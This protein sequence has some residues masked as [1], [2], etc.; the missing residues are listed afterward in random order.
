MPR[1]AQ[2]GLCIAAALYFILTALSGYLYSPCY[3]IAD[4]VY[5]HGLI[6][7]L[8]F[9]YTVFLVFLLSDARYRYY[10]NLLRVTFT[11]LSLTLV[12][13]FLFN[14]IWFIN[15]A[16]LAYLI[17]T[18]ALWRYFD[19][20]DKPR[21]DLF[22]RLAIFISLLSWIYFIY[23]LNFEN[24]LGFESRFSY[25]LLAFSF[26]VSL[27]LFSRIVDILKLSNKQVTITAIVLVSGVLS[28]FAG[29]LFSV[30]WLEKISAGSLLVL[31]LAYLML[32]VHQ[33]NTTLAIAFF[34]LLLTGLSG[35]WFLLEYT[36]TGEQNL[37]I[38][39]MH[40]HLAH[41]AWATY[42]IFYLSAQHISL[43]FRWQIAIYVSLF[44]SLAFLS[45]ALFSPNTWLLHSS[46]LFFLLSGYL[47]GACLIKWWQNQK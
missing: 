29:M 38:L 4:G 13:A 36:A 44:L 7:I 24:F 8:G 16:A 21:E 47:M 20:T 39:R 32:A 18:G 11:V 43:S 40:A 12:A 14:K 46:V 31:I 1:R 42:G 5:S 35:V 28:M 30:Y 45:L 2:L 34:G 33:R 6:G 27:L 26:P 23:S 19:A 25:T 9:A 10:A 17:A 3:R 37:N 22:L 15:L 41:F